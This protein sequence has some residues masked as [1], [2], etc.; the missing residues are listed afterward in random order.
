MI[1]TAMGKVEGSAEECIEPA[2]EP[3][4]ESEDDDEDEAEAVE[5]A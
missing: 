5:A 1:R 4:V 3:V 2:G